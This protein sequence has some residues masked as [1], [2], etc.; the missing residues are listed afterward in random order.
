MTYKKFSGYKVA[1]II[2]K[3]I[4]LKEN[5]AAY[6]ELIVSLCNIS[7]ALFGGDF[8]INTKKCTTLGP[9]IC[10]AILYSLNNVVLDIELNSTILALIPKIKK[11]Y[12]CNGIST[13]FEGF[14]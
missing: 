10:K 9:E 8:F 1:M 6:E 5:L 4:F 3:K 11:S 14:G 13:Y 12:M 7:I 2:L